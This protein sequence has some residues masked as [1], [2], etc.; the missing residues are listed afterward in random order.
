MIYEFEHDVYSSKP[1]IICG[2]ALFATHFAGTKTLSQLSVIYC[3]VFFNKK[4][5]WSVISQPD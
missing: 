2:R 4:V 3:L 5:F 1:N